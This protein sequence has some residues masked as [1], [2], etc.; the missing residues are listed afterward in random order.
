LPT[1][2]RYDCILHAAALAGEFR[3]SGW[4]WVSSFVLSAALVLVISYLT[5]AYQAIKAA[6]TNPIDVIRT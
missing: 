5:I 1:L 4:Y 6:L 2:L 3:L